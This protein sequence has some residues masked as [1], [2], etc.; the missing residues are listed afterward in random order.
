MYK[1]IGQD[2]AMEGRRIPADTGQEV[3][4]V[5]RPTLCIW[6]RGVDNT[7][8]PPPTDFTGEC[9]DVLLGDCDGADLGVPA[10]VDDGVDGGFLVADSN[11]SSRS[12]TPLRLVPN[13]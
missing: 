3:G 1:G 2:T 13:S 5:G 12:D 4:S 9:Q 10:L 7:S 11:R 8:T 6:S